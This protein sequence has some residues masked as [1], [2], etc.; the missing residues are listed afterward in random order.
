MS[1]IAIL[2]GAL[3]VLACALIANATQPLNVAVDTDENGNWN[4]LEIYGQFADERYHYDTDNNTAVVCNFAIYRITWNPEGLQI[5]KELAITGQKAAIEMGH[6]DQT[7]YNDH[8]QCSHV[9]I[10]PLGLTPVE[11]YPTLANVSISWS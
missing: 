5:G 2:F 7:G 3:L 8:Y 1:K 4:T 6:W 11:V 9:H 10:E